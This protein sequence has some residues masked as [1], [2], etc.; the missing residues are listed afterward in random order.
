MVPSAD[1]DAAAELISQQLSSR[2]THRFMILKIF[3]VMIL[4]P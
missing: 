1:T 2:Q 4:L 3:T